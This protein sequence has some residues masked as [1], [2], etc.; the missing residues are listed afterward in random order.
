MRFTRLKLSMLFVYLVMVFAMLPLK[1]YADAACFIGP[2]VSA[3]SSDDLDKHRKPYRFSLPPGKLVNDI[4]G[5]AI[6]GEN[7]YNFVWFRDGTVSAGTSNDLDRFRKP[8]RYTL[9]AGKTPSD[10]VGMAI[11]GENNYNFVWFSDGTVSAGTSNDLDKFRKPYRYKLP[12]PN[13]RPADIVGMGVD[14]E[15]NFNFVWFVGK[16]SKTC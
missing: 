7:N 9:P 15:N 3:G 1:A 6:D 13:I 12:L 8:Y 2:G 5:M 14:G 10:I 4:V 16:D 11:D